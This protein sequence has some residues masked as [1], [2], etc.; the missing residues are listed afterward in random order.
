M[1][2]IIL[3]AGRG[4]RLEKITKNKPKIL[5]S[6]DNITLIEYHLSILSH[7]G[8]NKD[9]I[10]VVVGYKGDL[11]SHLISN[12]AQIIYNN[13]YHLNNIVSLFCALKFVKEDFLL[14]NGDL[15]CPSNFLTKIA[16]EKGDVLAIDNVKKLGD[17]EMKVCIENG[18][19][20]EISKDIPVSKSSGEYIGLAKFSYEGRTLL[21]NEIGSL[22]EEGYV[23]E[24]YEKGID[25]LC[26]YHSI[27]P[28]FVHGSWVEIDTEDDYNKA[29]KIAKEILGDASY[30]NS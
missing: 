6:I 25:N 7:L 3:G 17:E 27:F 8:F 21:Y 23:N 15:F 18:R 12:N 10:Y 20:V 22:I 16:E 24:W 5:L 19:I 30:K 14:I 11:V 13:N 28:F 26:K 1:K 4:R 29:K 2:A 9:D